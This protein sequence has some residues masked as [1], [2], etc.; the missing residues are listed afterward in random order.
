MVNPDHVAVV[1][2]DGIATPNV[3]GVDIGDSNVP[4]LGQWDSWDSWLS[5]LTG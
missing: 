3:L 2:G 1:D 4:I 5:I